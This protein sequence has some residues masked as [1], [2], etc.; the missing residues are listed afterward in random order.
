MTTEFIIAASP[1]TAL[2]CAHLVRTGELPRVY[3]DALEAIR[4]YYDQTVPM[5]R[6]YHLFKCDEFGAA[7]VMAS[8]KSGIELSQLDISSIKGLA[9]RLAPTGGQKDD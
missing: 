7:T 4:A 3:R 9:K 2:I 8:P 5:Q 1:A 6:K